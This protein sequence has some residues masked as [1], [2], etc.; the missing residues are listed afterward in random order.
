MMEERT[1]PLS[2]HPCLQ[3][4]TL[5]PYFAG[6]IDEANYAWAEPLTGGESDRVFS[7]SAGRGC[8]VD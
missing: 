3:E 1:I 8:M 4:F 2:H 6:V 7:S 5:S